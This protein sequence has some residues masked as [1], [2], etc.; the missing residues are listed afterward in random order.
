MVNTKLALEPTRSVALTAAALGAVTGVRSMAAPALLA[1]EFSAHGVADPSSTLGQMLATPGASRVL[2]LFAG[3][4]MIADKTPFV[5]DR[6]QPGPLIGRA[7]IGALTAMTYAASRRQ[8]LLLPGVLGAAGAVAAAFA[9]FH[10]RRVV[11]ERF[12]APDRM[13]G[14]V[15]DALVLGAGKLLARSID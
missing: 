3:G 4:E 6:T 1:H 7:A 13:V 12:G 15:E 2:A 8:S 11:T 9:A 10:V 14:L 5:P